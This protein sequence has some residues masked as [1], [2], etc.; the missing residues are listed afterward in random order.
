MSPNGCRALMTPLRFAPRPGHRGKAADA[1]ARV[2]D[3]CRAPACAPT[4]QHAIHPMVGADG[5][6]SA[7]ARERQPIDRTAAVLG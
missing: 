2:A 6:D 4:W 5:C 7:L 3:G 1:A